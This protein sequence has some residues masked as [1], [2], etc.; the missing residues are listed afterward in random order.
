MEWPRP[1]HLLL[2][3]GLAAVYIVAGKLGLRLAF[4]HPSATPVWAPTGI[5]LAAFLLAGARVWPAIFIGAFLVN[6][7]TQ[8][9]IATSLGIAAGNTLEGL[10][11]AALVTRWAGG[12]HAFDHAPSTFMFIVLAAGV[13]TTVSATLGVTT[14]VL[15]GF[16]AWADVASMWV[17][18][19]LGDATGAIVV[20]PALLLWITDP[21]VSWRTARVVEASGLAAAVVV[22]GLAAFSGLA[23][24]ADPRSPME[25][26]AIPVLLWAAFRFGPRG[27]AT[28]VLGLSTVA[29]AGTLQGAGPFAVGTPNQ[30]LLLLQAFMGV[31][32]GTSLIVAAAVAERRAVEEQL[33]KWSVSDL[34]TG[35]ANYRQLVSVLESEIRRSDRTERPFALLFLDLDNLKGIN[36]RHGHLVGSRALCRVA[37]VLRGSC[38]VVDVVARFGGDEFAVVLP[39]SEETSARHLAAR[40]AER[41]GRDEEQP[42]ISA[43]MGVAVYP[44]DGETVEAL[45]GRA[46]NLLYEA[47]R[48]RQEA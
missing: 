6:L 32:A 42:P 7:T 39:E 22:V 20:A 10:V 4:A 46:D 24:I 31:A 17:T 35:L 28:A 13:A 9:T 47:K 18:W 30:S 38:R 1:R 41:L 25:F 43:S 27:A 34:L 29:I 3:A 12:R 26:V 23:P 11:G 40:I 2:L 19:W 48:R 21:R 33:R 37:E 45:I 16:A 36:D 14:L 5:A 8:G 15:G 44:R